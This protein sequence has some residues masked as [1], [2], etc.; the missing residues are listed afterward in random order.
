M[1][2]SLFDSSQSSGGL[3]A[4]CIHAYTSTD[5][6]VC[7]PFA[8]EPVLAF[9]NSTSDR[10]LLSKNVWGGVQLA[11]FGIARLRAQGAS[12]Y[13]HAESLV[14]TGVHDTSTRRLPIVAVEGIVPV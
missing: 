7:F 5:W 14:W 12:I 4:Y 1:G 3:R 13:K 10:S 8:G 6:L 2:A 11:E 9:E